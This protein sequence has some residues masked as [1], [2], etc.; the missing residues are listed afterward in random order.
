MR[1]QA[2]D[3]R[4]SP[5]PRAVH[6]DVGRLTLD[7]YS[8]AQRARFV[9]SLRDRLADLAAGD[10]PAWPAA[11]Q[12]RVEHLD[13]GVLPASAAPEE[14]AQRVAAALLAHLCAPAG[15]RG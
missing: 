9:S 4:V 15:R 13:A 1:P 11:A 6:F 2:A 7:G 3:R 12:R 5:A 8:A 14:A 10:G